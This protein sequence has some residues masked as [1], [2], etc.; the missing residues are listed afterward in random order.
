[1]KV[2]IIGAGGIA[3]KMARTLIPLE[4][5]ESYAIASRNREKAQ[6]FAD[7]WSFQKAYG[8]YEALLDD[9]KVDLVYVALP[10]SHHCEWT[11]KSLR[12]GKNV[13]CEK[14]F[15][16][17]KK[18]ARE[19]I[20]VAEEKNLLLAEAMKTRYMPSRKM[21]DDIIASGDIGEVVSVTS[22]IGFRIDMNERLMKP[23]L[24]GGCLLDLTVYNLNFTS[25]IL[26]N[27]IKRIAASMVPTATGVDG[28]DAV[29]LEYAG[30]K[31]AT[32]FAT[33]HTLTDRTGLICGREG[34]ISIQNV[35]NPQKIT[36][37]GADRSSCDVK[38]ELSVPEQITGFEYEVLACQKAIEEGHIECEEMPHSE[39]LEI[40]GQ[41]DEIRRQFGLV[42]PFERE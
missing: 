30:G 31:A 15:A 17:N 7:K 42:Y 29:M 22:N 19:M 5:V 38:K 9:D 10:H 39:T 33:I 36:I 32:I 28:Q 6:A 24:A 37:F 41:M 23:E 12:A 18:Q 2:A 11:I 40:M 25:M 1:M 8:S 13:L 21:I 16:A 26:G 3:A 35:T 14:S 4:G 27:D 34:Y 20:S